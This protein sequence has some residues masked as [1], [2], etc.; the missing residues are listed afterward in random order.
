MVESNQRFSVRSHDFRKSR[1]E[2]WPQLAVVLPGLCALVSGDFC[3][4]Q[5]GRIDTISPPRRAAERNRSARSQLLLIVCKPRTAPKKAFL[6]KYGAA[7][8]SRKKSNLPPTQDLKS[9]PYRS[10]V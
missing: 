7:S 6:E 1:T 3:R 5:A 10:L 9:P 4:A 2:W 8:G